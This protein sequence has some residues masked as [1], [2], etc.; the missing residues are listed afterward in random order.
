MGP[1]FSLSE[2]DVRELY[3]SQDW[4]DSVSLV[5]EIDYFATNSEAENARYTVSGVTSM[6]ELVFEIKAKS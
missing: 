6:F 3:E 1:P 2:S 5:E 4:V